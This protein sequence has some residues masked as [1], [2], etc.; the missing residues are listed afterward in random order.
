MFLGVFVIKAIF[1]LWWLKQNVIFQI[2]LTKFDKKLKKI[3]IARFYQSF[4]RV[5]IFL[6]FFTKIV[7]FFKKKW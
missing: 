1:D 7:D 4:Y 2:I 6:I 3:M 5:L